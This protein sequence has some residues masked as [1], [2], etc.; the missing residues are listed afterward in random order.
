MG[1]AVCG[2]LAAACI[3]VALTSEHARAVDHEQGAA[4]PIGVVVA[5]GVH[6]DAEEQFGRFGAPGN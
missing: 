6:L 3:T 1:Q 5:H 4:A 2:D